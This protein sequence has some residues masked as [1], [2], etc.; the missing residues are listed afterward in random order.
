[1]SSLMAAPQRTTK[2]R[3]VTQR[4]TKVSTPVLPRVLR[5]V[6]LFAALDRAFKRRVVWVG[7]PPGAGKTTLVASYLQ[8][9]RRPVLWDRLDERDADLPSFVHYVIAATRSIS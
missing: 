9:R 2:K 7:G 6:R 1:M 5:R 8:A 3:S 4:P